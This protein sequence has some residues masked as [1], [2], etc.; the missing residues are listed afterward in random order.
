MTELVGDGDEIVGKGE[1]LGADDAQM[2]F[3]VLGGL[4]QIEG[5]DVVA[6]VDALVESLK[7]LEE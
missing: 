3:D 6:D 5:R 4:G 7:V 1:T 2:M